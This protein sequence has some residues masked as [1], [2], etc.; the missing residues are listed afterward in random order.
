MKILMVSSEVFPFAKVGGLGDVIP[1]LSTALSSR[2]HDVK[3]FMP[4]YYRIDRVLLDR[5][6]APLEIRLGEE[7]LWGALYHSELPESDLDIWFLEHEGL[8][9]RQ[10]IYGDEQNRD[11][12]DNIKRFAV[13][14]KAAFSLCRQIQ[15]FPDIIHSHD[16]ASGLVQTYLKSHE[17]TGQ[18]LECAGVFSIHNIG[19][20][21]IFPADD[22]PVL[23]FGWEDFHSL[24]LEYHQKIST[25]KSALVC[26]D[27]LTTV[28]P[29]YAREILAPELGFGMDGVLRERQSD[30]SGI[31]NGMDYD[32]WNP[33]RDQHIPYPYDVESLQNKA[34]NK[35]FVQQEANLEIST[36]PPM[37]GIVSRLVSQK[38]FALLMGES[39]EHL[40]KI[41][42]ELDLQMVILGTGEDWIEESIRQVAS[43]VPN[44]RAYIRYNEKMSHVI[45]AASDFF[46]M[47]S[48][49]EPCGLTQMY[50]LRY[51]TLPIVSPTG[52]LL[53]SVSDIIANPGTGTGI[54]I[55]GSGENG[56]DITEESLFE[57][58]SRAVS[59][60]QNRREDYV[61]AQKRGMAIR[62]SW[63]VAALGYEEVYRNAI[64][65]R[66]TRK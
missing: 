29:N 5:H 26:A 52:G 33:G 10:G 37:I 61:A 40:R 7:Q 35:N 58:I 2:G 50:A 27:Q 42:R 13:L 39:G 65:R 41:C 49:Y 31:L 54:L 59:L 16:W 46:L 34:L 30:L 45:Q 32:E 22:L 28:S 3:I 47:P 15:W 19:Y 1:H 17:A 8:F 36:R 6:P 56:R 21:G 20:Q 24:G 66:K 18:F 12:P 60:W 23:G 57:S 53:D 9:G 62:F 14:S 63:D 25:L 55:E 38:G 4:R 43:E 64:A 11:F 48:L 51:G 44:L